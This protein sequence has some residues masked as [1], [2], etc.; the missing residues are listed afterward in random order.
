VRFTGQAARLK[1][2]EAIDGQFVLRGTLQGID[3]KGLVLLET[4]RS[5]VL[6]LPLESIQSARLVFEMGGAGA[7]GKSPGRASGRPARAKP[8]GRT[9]IGRAAKAARSQR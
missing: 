4:E 2:N 6:S 3:E 5:E 1:L 9:E 8:D 7:R